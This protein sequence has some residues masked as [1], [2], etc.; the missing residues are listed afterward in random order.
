MVDLCMVYEERPAKPVSIS[1]E[2]SNMFRFRCSCYNW[3]ISTYS[4]LVTDLL[5]LVYFQTWVLSVIGLFFYYLYWNDKKH[6]NCSYK[7]LPFIQISIPLKYCTLVCDSDD[8]I[9]NWCPIHSKR[10]CHFPR[11][12]QTKKIYQ[13]RTKDENMR[14]WKDVLSLTDT[15]IKSSWR[16]A[17][18][19][20]HLFIHSN[21][22]KKQSAQPKHN[23]PNIWN[24]SKQSG[25]RAC[26][27]Q[28]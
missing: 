17:L 26:A 10:P 22:P 14:S 18:K 4:T 3:V 25:S 20:W 15:D 19:W 8:C 5:S 28:P 13:V 9:I 23:E 16:M 2:F 1:Y 27:L 12:K 24:P 21:V 7:F 11:I 6:S